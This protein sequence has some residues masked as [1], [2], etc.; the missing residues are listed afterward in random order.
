MYY[1]V[2]PVQPRRA[3]RTWMGMTL[4]LLMGVVLLLIT[5]GTAAG[6]VRWNQPRPEFAAIDGI[7]RRQ[8]ATETDY[9]P[10]D[11]ITRSQVQA[12]LESVQSAG[13]KVPGVDGIVKDAL[14]DQA[15]LPRN[16]RTEAGLKFMQHIKR[17]P[18]AYDRLDRLSAMPHGR[19]DI[20]AMIKG[21]DGWKLIDYM[22]KSEGGENLGKQLSNAPTGRHFN[23]PTGRI[24]TEDDLIRRLK[25]VYIRE[26]EARAKG[27]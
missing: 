6:A 18:G 16:L 12:V 2:P 27:R 4:W 19:Q 26:T 1:C 9:S 5:C 17:D 11:I 8:L 25:E 15:F 24:Y 13:W 3:V 23:K 7:V 10:G 22:T 20:L 14:E 21:P